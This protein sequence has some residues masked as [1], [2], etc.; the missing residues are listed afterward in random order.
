M[1]STSTQIFY[2]RIKQ[3]DKIIGCLIV[4]KGR[5]FFFVIRE[6]GAPQVICEC[7]SYSYN[8]REAPTKEVVMVHSDDSRLK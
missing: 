3:G 6:K 1:W 4:L 7:V 5:A 2:E 8:W